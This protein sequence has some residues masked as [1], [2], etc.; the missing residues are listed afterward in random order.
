MSAR[1]G[2]LARIIRFTRSSTQTAVLVAERRAVGE[3]EAQLVRADVGAGLAD[4]GAEALAQR[5][6]QEV[7]R[8]V[9]AL[10]RAAGVAVDL[11]EHPLA[12][13]Q[14]AAQRLEHERLVVAEAHD[15]D[16]LRA[17]AAVLALD[18]ARVVHLAAAGGVERGLD[19]LGQRAAVL[20]GHRRDRG[21]LLGRLVAG[22]DARGA[23]RGRERA[24]LLARV[25]P[26]L[27]AGADARARTRCSS[28]RDSKPCSST[29]RPRSAASSSVRSNGKPNVSCSLKASSA[30]MPS[31]PFAVAL[32]DHVVEHLQAGLERAV[33]RLLLGAQ[34]HVDGVGLLEQLAGSAMPIVSRTTSA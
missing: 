12:V 25:L 7:R 5:G 4:V 2:W 11:R 3:V 9:V 31:S 1:T 15:V 13:V 10:G 34:P 27:A 16:D 21:R 22:E 8:R 33:E 20:G 30:P 24:Q 6:V 23:R 28:I 17:A 19:E 14:L 26:T 29:P 32:G 18:H